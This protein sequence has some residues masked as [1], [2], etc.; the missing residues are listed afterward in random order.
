MKCNVLVQF[1]KLGE[2]VIDLQAKFN[3]LAE[4][5]QPI[6]R[7]G[8]HEQTR[9]QPHSSHRSLLVAPHA[10][11]VPVPDPVV[12]AVLMTSRTAVEAA[13]GILD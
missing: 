7:N 12:I 1:S 11:P 10:V 9:F 13:L 4:R 3:E 5:T 8:A 6:H 2:L